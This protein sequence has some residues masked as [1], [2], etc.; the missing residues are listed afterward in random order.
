MSLNSVLEETI[1]MSSDLSDRVQGVCTCSSNLT[2]LPSYPSVLQLLLKTS[3]NEL[4]GLMAM[5]Q[6]CITN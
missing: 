5:L 4:R 2:W 3:R 1:Q 6:R